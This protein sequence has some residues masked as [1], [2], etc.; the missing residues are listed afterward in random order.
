M[1][2]DKHE[3]VSRS[4]LKWIAAGIPC[5]L[6]LYVLS[7]GPVAKL[8]DAGLIG[9]HAGKI[10]WAIYAPLQLLDDIPGMRSVFNMY[11]F[12]VCN[13]DTMGDNTL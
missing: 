2:T 9:E 7:I 10:L 13:C 3:L 6:V 1:D 5:F 12:H 4:R 11:V 8:E